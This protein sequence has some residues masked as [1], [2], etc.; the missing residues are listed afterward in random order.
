[1]WLSLAAQHGIGS[2]LVAL[3]TVVEAMSAEEK[4]EG[5]RLLD[6]RRRPS[7]VPRGP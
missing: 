2:A 1:M 3:E 4:L 7:R 5:Q 6:A